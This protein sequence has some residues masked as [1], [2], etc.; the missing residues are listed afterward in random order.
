MA[1]YVNGSVRTDD[2]LEA[3]VP[4]FMREQID[5]LDAQR[6][7]WEWLSRQFNPIKGIASMKYNFLEQRAYPF[8]MTCD[9]VTAAGADEVHVDHP[10]YAHTDQLIYNTRLGEHYPM[11]SAIR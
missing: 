3:K 5:M 11:G 1:E 10:E 8:T 4:V 6:A 9:E 2:V 7:Y